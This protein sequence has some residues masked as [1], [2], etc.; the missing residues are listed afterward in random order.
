MLRTPF[1]HS[2]QRFRRA[3]QHPP[4]GSLLWHKAPR[5]LGT[6]TAI[7]IVKDC[8]AQFMKTKPGYKHLITAVSGLDCHCVCVLMKSPHSPHTS[9]H[10]SSLT[11]Q[12]TGF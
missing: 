7:S 10:T 4:L 1:S 9:A 12:L 8:Y 5:S 6:R 11:T 2:R 3:R